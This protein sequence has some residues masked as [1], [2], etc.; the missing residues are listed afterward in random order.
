MV[1][2]TLMNTAGADQRKKFRQYV[3]EISTAQNKMMATRI[4]AMAEHQRRH[5]QYFVL[6]TG[7][8]VAAVN[9]HRAGP[10]PP[11]VPGGRL[12]V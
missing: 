11:S 5:F 6:S 3:T 9:L 10:V 7:G 8:T 4:D 1:A 2:N 12:N